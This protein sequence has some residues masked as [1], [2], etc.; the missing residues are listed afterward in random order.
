M[1]SPEATFDTI[2]STE[3]ERFEDNRVFRRLQEGTVRMEHYHALLTT[4]FH[5][6][7]NGPYTFARAAVNCNWRHEAAKDYLLQ[8]AEEERTHWRWV[9]NDLSATGYTGPT[10]RSQPPHPSCQAFLGLVYYI[11]DQVP[12]ARLG[13]AAVLEGIGARH[14]TTY[15]R[16][17]VEGLQ[18]KPAQASFFLGHGQT[19]KTHTVELRHVIGEC[20]LESEDWVWMNHAA[21]MAGSFYRAMYDHD[22]YA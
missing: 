16:K 13:I 2:V 19:D 22:A 20:A 9:L 17:L 7:Y 5:Q 10:P 3:I 15:G 6:T 14:G 1:A 12:V 21:T 8:H 11:S 18:L 4:I